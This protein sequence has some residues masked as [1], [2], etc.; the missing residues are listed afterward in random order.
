[1]LTPLVMIPQRVRD[2]KVRNRYGTGI[3]YCCCGYSQDQGPLG[4][5]VIFGLCY[6]WQKGSA[7]LQIWG[8]ARMGRKIWSSNRSGSDII[9]VASCFD[10]WTEDDTWEQMDSYY[11]RNG[12]W[13]WIMDWRLA[14]SV[15][16]SR[17]DRQKGQQRVGRAVL[18]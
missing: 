14:K 6:S 16:N 15:D 2:P 1:V 4:C 12:Q 9:E 8:K 5:D 17:I 13:S 7:C 3:P 18:I 10:G 11:G